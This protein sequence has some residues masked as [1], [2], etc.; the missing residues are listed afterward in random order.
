MSLDKILSI[1]GKP[2][3][4]QLKTK[5]KSGF[6]VESLIDKKTS[7][8]GIN[9]NVSVLND[10]SIYTCSKEMPLKEVFKKIADKESNGPTINHKVGKKEL[11][12]Y[13]NEV[14]PEYDEER[15]YASDIKKVIQWYNLLESN[16]LLS[17]I[18]EEE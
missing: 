10:I 1:T 12:A 9:H 17:S 7:I 14:L 15:V 16:G 8:V 13:F 11:E 18:D 2:G 5:A 6:V 3:L 4:Y